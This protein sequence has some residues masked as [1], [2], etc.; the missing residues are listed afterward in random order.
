MVLDAAGSVCDNLAKKLRI[1]IYD[2]QKYFLIA[3]I[4][5]IYCRLFAEYM[6][7]QMNSHACIIYR[8]CSFSMS[9]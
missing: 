9:H 2:F 4:D 7:I 8:L 1:I 5:G 6:T 3:L